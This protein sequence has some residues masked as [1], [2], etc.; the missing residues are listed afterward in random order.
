MDDPFLIAYVLIVFFLS[1]LVKGAVGVGLATISLGLMAVLLELPQAIA[2][3]LIPAFLS[4]FWQAF[5]GGAGLVLLKRLWPFYLVGNLTLFI[6]ALA[7]TRVD[8]AYLTAL[9]GV[10]LIVYGL[11]NLTRFRLV[12]PAAS[13]RWLGVLLGGVSGIVTGMTGSYVVP[14]VMYL[15]GIGLPRDQFIQAMGILFLTL[16]ISLTVAL[17]GNNIWSLELGGLSLFAVVPTMIGVY[18][19]QRIRKNLSEGLFRSVL[20][21]SLV[22]LGV[23]LFVKAVMVA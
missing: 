6:G 14:G 15:Q 10:L 17:G 19:G 22:L 8:L 1:G 9:L 21:I 4:N 11:L 16:T 23:Y 7:L 2:L 12:I 5:S 13:E 3:M 18:F 20:L